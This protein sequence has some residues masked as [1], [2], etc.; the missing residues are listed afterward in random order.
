[1]IEEETVVL[2]GT[3]IF[4]DDLFVVRYCDRPMYAYDS[5]DMVP[6]MAVSD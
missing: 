3:V 6:E 5:W 4:R 1:M 2:P